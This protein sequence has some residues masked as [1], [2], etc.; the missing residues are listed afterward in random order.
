MA[1]SCAAPTPPEAAAPAP[2]APGERAYIV[3]FDWGSSRI[4]PRGREIVAEA[5][6]NAGGE[7]GSGRV[8]LQAFADRSGR[9]N[10]NQSLSE[11]RADAVAEEL[12]RRGVRRERVAMRAFGE[13]RS[14]VPTRDGEREGQNRGVWI[15]LR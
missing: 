11:R 1:A 14:F 15:V 7:G 3:F 4:G 10:R 13:N 5:A 12:A 8:E 6:R 9:S 2:P